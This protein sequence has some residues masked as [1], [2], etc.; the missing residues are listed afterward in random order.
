MSLFAPFLPL[1]I[2][3]LVLGSMLL[4]AQYVLITRRPDLGN[5]ARLPR[6]LIL[7]F[8][9]LASVIVLVVL[10]PVAE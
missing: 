4:V 9:T 8:L 3:A 10:S 2:A 5:E 7:F 1:I 6:Q